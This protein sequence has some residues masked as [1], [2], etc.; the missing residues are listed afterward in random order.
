MA[1]GGI[2]GGIFP[3]RV[4]MTVSLVIVFLIDVPLTLNKHFK[5]F[6]NYDYRKQTLEDIM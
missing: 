4:V 3:I 5:K 1:L 6:I 2:L